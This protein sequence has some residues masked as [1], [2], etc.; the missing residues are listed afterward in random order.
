MSLI[1]V[2]IVKVATREWIMPCANII[3][4]H[5]KKVIQ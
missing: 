4:F 1:P 3:V 2:F 5:Y